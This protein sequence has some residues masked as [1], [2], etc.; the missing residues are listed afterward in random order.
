MALEGII[1]CCK[2]RRWKDAAIRNPNFWVCGGANCCQS[3]QSGAQD[4]AQWGLQSD[5][6]VND[7]AAIKAKRG[8]GFHFN[9]E[10]EVI[11]QSELIWEA[12][13]NTGQVCTTV[14]HCWS[15][16]P[17][18]PITPSIHPPL[19]HKCPTSKITSHHPLL[20]PGL[21][22]T[23]K[24]EPTGTAALMWRCLCWTGM[25]LPASFD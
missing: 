13:C 18:G 17:T 9:Y 21:P 16:S 14:W 22:N 23:N 11:I 19:T 1:V 25:G 2:H 10:K 20:V 8:K 4:V 5:R 7:L 3:I 15:C 6:F 12:Q 24:P